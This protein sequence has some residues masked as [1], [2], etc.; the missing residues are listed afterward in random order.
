[1]SIVGKDCQIICKSQTP[2]MNFTVTQPT[3][4]YTFCFFLPGPNYFFHYKVEQQEGQSIS[5]SGSCLNIKW[6]GYFSQQYTFEM[7]MVKVC[8]INSFVFLSTVESS[9]VMKFV[10]MFIEPYAFWKA[11]KSPFVCLYNQNYIRWSYL[12]ECWPDCTCLVSTDFK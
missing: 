9:N 2:R 8:L 3:Q 7:I 4:S 11:T 6:F 5:L 1:M 10:C 12:S